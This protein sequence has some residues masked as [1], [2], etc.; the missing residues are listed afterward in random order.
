MRLRR[1][2][3]LILLLVMLVSASLS[4]PRSTAAFQEPTTVAD[5]GFKPADNGFPFQ[6]YGN[7]NTPVNLTPVEVRRLFGDAVCA[8]KPDDKGGC[9]LT[10]PA[11]EWMEKVNASMGGGHCDGM[12]T[13]ASVLYYQSLEK[14]QPDTFNGTPVPAL[15]FDKNEA[16][17]REIAYWFSTQFVPNVRTAE[18][19]TPPDVV[20]KTLLDAIPKK[21][22][23]YTIG[24]YQPDGKGGHSITPYA[25]KQK[26]DSVYWIMVYDNNFPKEEK[27]IEVDLKANTWTYFTASN[28]NEPGAKYVG[29]A[30]TVSLTL[31]ADSVRKGKLVC[32]ICEAQAAKVEGLAYQ[33]QGYN[34][35]WLE[36]DNKA[37]SNLDLVITDDAGHKL[38]TIDGKVV[39]EIPGAFY[40]LPRSGPT[41]LEDNQEPVYYVPLGVKVT[42]VI[43][44]SKATR[45]EVASLALI[46][47]G[48]DI[49]IEKITLKPG[50]KDTAVFS[51]D[52]TKLTY[53]PS[54]GES[55]DI[56]F[57]VVTPGADYAFG[58]YGFD[59][60]QGASVNAALDLTNG[61][62]SF[63]RVN[64]KNPAT[65]ALS[66]NRVDA[67]VDQEYYH[68]GLTLDPQATAAINYAK[69]DGKGDLT[70]EID[71]N[72]DGTPDKTDAQPNQPKPAAK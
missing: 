59:L 64:A 50:A 11:N 41:T 23:P 37:N 36:G 53:T 40:V 19:R 21:A 32:P 63:G 51:P 45:E 26:S 48:H 46:G 55:P 67:D 9:P 35:F 71:S 38:G 5:S 70:V 58:V 33:T 52:G 3:F 49:S 17:Q 61:K 12:A 10:P 54:N 15:P 20:I 60:D 29:D 69:W 7:E 1:H 65:Y 44:A 56:Y 2:H 39:N 24:I 28:P 4:A 62:F 31:T 72:G 13:L 27:Y 25:I 6:N 42:V 16:L 34:Q 14:Q 8:G 68:E 47:P 57:G 43:D 22:E 30:S 18:T 66:I